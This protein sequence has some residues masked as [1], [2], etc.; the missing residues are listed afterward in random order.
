MDSRIN[1][2]DQASRS[3]IVAWKS[4]SKPESLLATKTL[5]GGGGLFPAVTGGAPVVVGG[6][7][8]LLWCV[9]VVDDTS[10]EGWSDVARKSDAL[11]AR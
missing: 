10:E 3:E 1:D 5:F 4:I 2:V 11:V 9:R 6:V 7:S 8:R